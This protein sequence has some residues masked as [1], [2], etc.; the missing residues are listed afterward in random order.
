LYL[1]GAYDKLRDKM[2]LCY[3]STERP[4]VVDSGTT[5]RYGW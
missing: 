2:G 3:H 5:S 4:Q 1:N